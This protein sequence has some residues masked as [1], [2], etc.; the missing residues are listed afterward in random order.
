LP[1]SVAFFLSFL[2]DFSARRAFPRA[3]RVFLF[4]FVTESGSIM[5]YHD[6]TSKT[7]ERQAFFRQKSTE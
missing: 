7:Q 1:L 6:L 5:I 3:A 2:L 4:G